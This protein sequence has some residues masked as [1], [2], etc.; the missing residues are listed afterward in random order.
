MIM[1]YLELP[2]IFAQGTFK[3]KINPLTIMAYLEQPDNNTAIYINGGT[4]FI[5]GM[6]IE[7]YE[8]AVSIYFKEANKVN[9]SNLK[10]IN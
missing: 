1:L 2:A 9:R 3:L 10:I 4:M 6:S 8:Q 7:E 5:I